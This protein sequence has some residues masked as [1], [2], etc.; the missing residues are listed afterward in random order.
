MTLAESTIEHHRLSDPS[1]RDGHNKTDFKKGVHRDFRGLVQA[2]QRGQGSAGPVGSLSPHSQTVRNLQ[3]NRLLG[4]QKPAALTKNQQ[5]HDKEKIVVMMGEA[6]VVKAVGS[7]LVDPGATLTAAP[8]DTNGAAQPPQLRSFRRVADLQPGGVA[9]PEVD[10]SGQ[11][12]AAATNK[13]RASVEESRKAPL[14]HVDEN[15]EGA[16]YGMP[17]ARG[18]SSLEEDNIG[19]RERAF[20]SDRRARTGLEQSFAPHGSRQHLAQVRAQG[21]EQAAKRDPRPKDGGVMLSTPLQYGSV[22][23]HHGRQQPLRRS[24][25][26]G[27][28]Q[29]KQQRDRTGSI[30]HVPDKTQAVLHSSKL[31]Q[32]ESDRKTAQSALTNTI[33]ERRLREL[34]G[35]RDLFSLPTTDVEDLLREV[36]EHVSAD[37]RDFGLLGYKAAI[38]PIDE[39]VKTSRSQDRSLVESRYGP[40]K[41]IQRFFKE[42]RAEQHEK[43]RARCQEKQQR[44]R[45]CSRAP[46]YS[47]ASPRQAATGIAGPADSPPFHEFKGQPQIPFVQEA[48]LLAATAGQDHLLQAEMGTATNLSRVSSPGSNY[49]KNRIFSLHNPKKFTTEPL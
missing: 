4:K 10:V 43:V 39:V 32:I 25:T 23:V 21:P 6:G 41:P 34:L 20:A 3:G 30:R 15:E 5:V 36:R 46:A 44:R 7:S 42:N 13:M 24:G 45:H 26:L 40:K 2:S 49:D 11:H 38:K 17:D 28:A 18:Y 22:T 12:P 1:S 14:L 31:G 8:K 19:K 35:N 47:P 29:A 37:V 48:A 27:A 33:D 16:A 9:R